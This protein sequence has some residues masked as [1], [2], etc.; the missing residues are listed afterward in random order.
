MSKL[1]TSPEVQQTNDT[2]TGARQSLAGEASSLQQPLAG[3]KEKPAEPSQLDFGAAPDIYKQNGIKLAQS[4]DSGVEPKSNALEGAI[5]PKD[6]KSEK[7]E[8]GKYISEKVGDKQQKNL[9][10]VNTPKETAEKVLGDINKFGEDPKQ[11]VTD[12]VRNNRVVGLGESHVSP[13]DQRE[14]NAHIMPELKKAGATHLAIEAPANSQPALDEYMRTGKLDPKDLPPLLRDQDYLNQLEAARTS[15]LKIVAVDANRDKGE[16]SSSRMNVASSVSGPN[17][18]ET[19]AS[20]IDAILKENPNN[21]VVFAVGSLHLN[22]S[23]HPT[24]KSAADLLRKDHSVATVHPNSDLERS[25][26]VP[27]YPL[28]EITTGLRSPV[29]ISSEK[30]KNVADLPVS[31]LK[32]S[33]PSREKQGD[34]D[35]TIIYP[36][37]K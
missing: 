34:W 33:G 4:G 37:R 35:Y 20:N 1:E 18:D 12:L 10:E 9:D 15:G 11:A 17:R 30:A 2:Q 28:G 32:S 13:N 36:P 29:A 27:I 24:H 7:P 31:N 23:D 21:K 25:P 5:D 3:A 8:D 14:F 22:K 16:G 26:G 6:G 19:M